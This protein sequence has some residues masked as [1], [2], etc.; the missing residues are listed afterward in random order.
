LQH[1]LTPLALPTK[2]ILPS[3]DLSAGARDSIDSKTSTASQMQLLL[4]L[5]AACNVFYL[6]SLDTDSLTGPLAVKK[7]VG[8]M[9][10]LRPNP[11]LVHFK[12]SIL[13]WTKFD[14]IT[15]FFLTIAFVQNYGNT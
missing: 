12:V 14:G 6:F 3:N 10:S 11:T 15:D 13:F 2:L 9:L 8:Q 4:S 1:T 7:T 5:G